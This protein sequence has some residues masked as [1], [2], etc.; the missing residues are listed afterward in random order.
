MHTAKRPALRR[1]WMIDRALRAKTFPTAEELAA[2][3][4]V[5]VKTIRRD[6]DSLRNDRHAPVAYNRA[7]QGW[8]YTTETYR[9]P[10]VI[11]TEGEL[12]AMFLAGQA[13]R[14]VEGTPYAAD[15]QIAIEKLSEFLPDEISVHWETL[16]QTQSFHQTVTTLQD[17]DVFRQ[18][19]DAVLHHQQLRI[20][21]W[22][23]SR[24]A[25]SE[26]IIDPYHLACIDGAWYLIAWCHRR[27]STR[28]FAPA[29]IRE[30]SPTGQTFAPPADFHIADYFDG[31]FK[32]VSE[33][34]QPMQKVRL[35]FAASAGKYIREK[36]FHP[37][38]KLTANPDG[39]VLLE[40]SLRSLIEVRRWVLSWGSECE[41]LEPAALRADIHRE[42][43]G[44][45]AAS[46]PISHV[47]NPQAIDRVR[48]RQRTPRR[49]Q[50]G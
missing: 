42:A 41:V 36:I 50:I 9:L 18:L 8:E 17:I 45:V 11:M 16:D 2:Q 35:K 12:V 19:A 7:R 3:A 14:Q 37:T 10:A 27:N 6:L 22:T 40:L 29:R 15:L 30:I 24:D 33:S 31:T 34:H 26:R 49:K 47:K 23:A 32:V 4:E 21:Y 43:V 20:R 1:L 28:T 39:S 38:Q 44:M 5:D 25:E 48:Q 46:S 13:L